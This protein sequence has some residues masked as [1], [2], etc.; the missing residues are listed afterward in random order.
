MLQRAH[1][2]K[3]YDQKFR[4]LKDMI[5]MMGYHAE[6]MI[7]DA[8]RSLSER[9]SG[10]AH[11][12]ILRDETL[13]RLELDVDRLCHEI[14]ALQHPLAGD[15]RIVTTAFKIVRDIERIGDLAVNIAERVN[16]LLQEP[17]VHRLTTLPLMAQLVQRNL[18]QSL[19]ALISSDEPL[20]MK[21]IENDRDIDD[22][23]DKIFRELLTYMMEEPKNVPRCLKLIFIAK[24][25]ERVGDHA[26]NIAEMALFMIRGDDSR[27][28]YLVG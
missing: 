28:S 22:L 3:Q 17:H 15:L 24:H 26:T 20:A 6:Q 25:L 19:D 23:N 12:V 5:L 1:T 2:N 27:R 11:D 10:I 14:L 18:S 16:E 8:M 7:A 9:R 4:L 21:V 13:D